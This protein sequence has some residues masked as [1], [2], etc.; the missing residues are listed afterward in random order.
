M[1]ATD[2]GCD[3]TWCFSSSKSR[4]GRREDL[5]AASKPT[6]GMNFQT[7]AT[8]PSPIGPGFAGHAPRDL[9]EQHGPRGGS[10]GAMGG[11]GTVLFPA[12]S[13]CAPECG[14]L[15]S[16]FADVASG[17]GQAPDIRFTRSFSRAYKGQGCAEYMHVDSLHHRQRPTFCWD[18]SH[19]MTGLG[20]YICSH[21]GVP[22]ALLIGIVAAVTA[23]TASSMGV[24]LLDA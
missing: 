5:H 24:R 10:Y 16:R 8:T 1:G 13:S 6:A 18:V 4:L 23:L 20:G 7:A 21:W 14:P 11:G 3:T 22:A 17:V 12:E 15:Q 19:D 9:P 2:V